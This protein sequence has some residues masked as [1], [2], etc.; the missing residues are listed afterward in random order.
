MNP[1]SCPHC[2]NPIYDPDAVLCHFCGESLERK[3]SGMLGGLRSG[4]V[5]WVFAAVATMIIISFILS[6]Q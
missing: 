2:K 1:V 6:L 4:M 5:K 3:S